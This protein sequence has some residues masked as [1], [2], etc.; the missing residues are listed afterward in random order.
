S[1]RPLFTSN[2]RR[3]V[4][5]TALSTHRGAIFQRIPTAGITGYLRSIS[6]LTPRTSCK[7]G[8][9]MYVPPTT[10]GALKSSDKSSKPASY[11]PGWAS[12][13]IRM[14]SESCVSNPITRLT[15]CNVSGS[16][17][18]SGR[19]NEKRSHSAPSRNTPGL[20][21]G[22]ITKCRIESCSSKS[23]TL[24]RGLRRTSPL[25]TYVS[26]A[27]YSPE[28]GQ[29]QLSLLSSANAGVANKNG[30]EKARKKDRGSKIFIR[31]PISTAVPAKQGNSLGDI[32]HHH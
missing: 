22:V 8:L 6:T 24:F 23:R 28:R 7:F 5:R 32:F 19:P 20:I 31:S 18:P 13:R 26:S 4:G 3:G 2:S 29:N 11:T 15:A 1:V 21:R 9:K 30:A 14:E 12:T 27:T 16:G 10:N 25:P 17:A